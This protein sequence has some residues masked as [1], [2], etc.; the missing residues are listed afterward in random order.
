MINNEEWPFWVVSFGALFPFVALL[1][2]CVCCRKRT[3]KNELLGLA[4]MVTI[5][6]PEE[7]ADQN[8]Q[9]SDGLRSSEWVDGSHAE[10]AQ[11]NKRSTTTANRSLP[12]I[13]VYSDRLRVEDGSTLWENEVN[14]DTSSE[15]YAT[16]E[17]NKR[18]TES[19]IHNNVQA[20]PSVAQKRDMFREEQKSSEQSSLSQTDDN[21]SPY[22]QLKSEHPYDRLRKNEHPY[23]QVGSSGQSESKTSFRAGAASGEAGSSSS[24]VTLRSARPVSEPSEPVAPPRARRA[25]SQGSPSPDGEGPV[26]SIPAAT[27]IAGRVS[28]NQ[29]LPYMTPPIADQQA[30]FSGD[31]QDS[32]G[33]TSISVR[34]PLANI[35]AQT[36]APR[37]RQPSRERADPHY[38]TVSD[39][40]DEMYAA[41]EDP[42]QLVYT[43]GSE[44]YAQ[45]QPVARLPAASAVVPEDAQYSAPQ[46]PSVDSLKH[47][48]Q[49]HSRQ[50]SSSS[51]TSSVANIGSPKPEKRQANSPLPPPPAGSPELHG[52]SDRRSDGR[53]DVALAK[54]LEEMYAKVMKKKRGAVSEGEPIDIEGP[55]CGLPRQERR[56]V[57][58]ADH[59]G[60]SVSCASMDSRD[61][62]YRSLQ[63][64]QLA[65]TDSTS[66]SDHNLSQESRP[67]F[68]LNVPHDG[69]SVSG[70]EAFVEPG[71]ESLGQ[72]HSIL[73]SDPGYE[74]VCRQPSDCDPNYE[75][76]RPRAGR[77]E[78]GYVSI[79]E[80]NLSLA[81]SSHPAPAGAE[82]YDCLGTSLFPGYERVRPRSDIEV[83][84]D[85]ASLG[86]KRYSCPFKSSNDDGNDSGDP[87]YESVSNEM[88]DPNYKML[89]HEDPNYES[90]NY[91]VNVAAGEP[92]YERLNNEPRD[93]DME[94][95]ASDYERMHTSPA[96]VAQEPR[97]GKPETRDADFAECTKPVSEPGYEVVGKVKQEVWKKTGFLRSELAHQKFWPLIAG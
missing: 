37:G 40:S 86:R 73:Y 17:E 52:G 32:K 2:A 1:A 70:H 85:Y 9:Q 60:D 83:E 69:P 24:D 94:T 13:P 71:Y 19:L 51:A 91:S 68:E 35:K 58:S 75:E 49:V 64:A 45:I 38:A 20:T 92:P 33:Y 39:D 7:N 65:D 4:G 21:F 18:V 78:P 82:F 12:D 88:Q 47:V 23:A 41:I 63:D 25:A 97:S 8:H 74:R 67:V 77:D 53:L 29:E 95:T 84:P 27:A 79:S 90:V 10:A 66:S 36:Q 34:E 89:N 87:N 56:S 14:G 76:L 93:S 72:P 61:S 15:L 43:S 59:K 30:H 44:T 62:E 50:A 57:D 80:Q 3:P 42:N 6:N 31:S 26:A 11:P 46:P 55:A 96:D 81:D 16:V 22:S 48:A 28:A 5:T 54:N